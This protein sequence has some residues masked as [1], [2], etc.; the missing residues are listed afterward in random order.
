MAATAGAPR[1]LEGSHEVVN[2]TGIPD[3]DLDYY[4]YELGRLQ[5]AAREIIRVFDQPAEVV[6]AL[7]AF[8]AAVPFEGRGTR[9]PTHPTTLGS[10]TSAGSVRLV[11]IGSTGDVHYLVDPRYGHHDAAEAL[12]EALFTILRAGLRAE[13]DRGQTFGG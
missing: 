5:D 9:S 8:D 7:A 2:L 13:G 11:R 4:V 12:A 3:N 1:L 6:D 10:M